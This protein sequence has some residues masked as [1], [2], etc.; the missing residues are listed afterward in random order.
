MVSRRTIVR[1]KIRLAVARQLG[2]RTRRPLIEETPRHFQEMFH[3]DSTHLHAPYPLAKVT[4]EYSKLPKETFGNFVNPETIKRAL[5]GQKGKQAKNPIREL[6]NAYPG[7]RQGFETSILNAIR[8]RGM[9]GEAFWA[10]VPK[11]YIDQIVARAKGNPNRMNDEVGK[12][13]QQQWG[14]SVAPRTLLDIGSFS[15]GTAVGAIRHLSPEQKRLLRVVLVDVNKVAL[16]DYAVPALVA[17]GVPRQ[18]IRI[19]PTGFYSA[20]TAYGQM[21]RP[22]HEKGQPRYD[23]AFKELIEKVD[24]VTAGASTLNFATDLNPLLR[25]VRRMLK[26][27]GIFVDWE[28]GSDE[29]RSPTVSTRALK[30]EVLERKGDIALTKYDA[31][32]SFLNFWMDAYN[33]PPNVKEKLFDDIERSK[34]FNFTYWCEMNSEWMEYERRQAGLPEAEDP[35]GFRNRAYRFGNAMADAARKLGF[36]TTKPAYPLANPGNKDTGNTHWLLTM[37]KKG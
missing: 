27:N 2:I 15:G 36:S 30:Y 5:W 13:V 9:K 22:L 21:L 23:K 18:N 8:E 7:L 11:P 31:Y 17:A 28:W 35:I 19:I 25:S 14:S 1:K 6:L 20:A 26:Q 37:Q 10:K 34:L 16:R 33:Y 32:V 3:P 29:V 4:H 12:I 24:V